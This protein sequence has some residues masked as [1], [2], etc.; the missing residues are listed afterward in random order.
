[1]ASAALAL[2]GP[3][4]VFA[5]NKGKNVVC[6]GYAAFDNSGTLRPWT[7]KRRPVGHNDVLIEVKYASICHV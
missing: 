5:Q 1:M 6:N 7:F 2:S 3:G 4:L